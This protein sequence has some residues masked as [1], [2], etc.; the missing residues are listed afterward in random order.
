MDG[1]CVSLAEAWVIPRKVGATP[2]PPLAD[3]GAAKRGRQTHWNRLCWYRS[4]LTRSR[5]GKMLHVGA[6]RLVWWQLVLRSEETL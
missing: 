6:G 1:G 3:H 4:R 2:P 5:C